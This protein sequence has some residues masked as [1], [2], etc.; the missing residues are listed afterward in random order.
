MRP[1]PLGPAGWRGCAV[2]L[3]VVLVGRGV[4]TD[5]LHDFE[6]V[7]PLLDEASGS[8]DIARGERNIAIEERKGRRGIR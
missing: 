6:S 7:P 8:D 3:K 1:S 4:E 2:I 5:H